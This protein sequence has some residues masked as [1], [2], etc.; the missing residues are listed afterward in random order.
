M[1]VNRWSS[2]L[3]FIITTS[4]F[5]VGLGNIWRFPYITGQNGGGAFLLIYLVLIVLIGLPLLT[6]EIALGRMSSTTTLVGFGQ[7]SKRESWNLLGWLSVI[8]NLLIMSYYVMIL[9][10]VLV[11]LWE[12]LTGNLVAI[13]TDLLTAHFTDVASS[14][15]L[16]IAIVMLIMLGVAWI[17]SQGF[18]KGLERYTKVMM[19]LL[20]LMMIALAVWGA[21]LPGAA[22]GYEW[23]LKPDFAK[24]NV[25]VILTALGQVFFSIGVGMAIAFSFGSYTPREEDLVSSTFWIVMADTFFAVL[26]GLMMFPVIF[27]FG[28]APDSGPNL[29]FVTMASAFAQLEMGAL[30]GGVFFLLL[31]FGGFTSLVASVQGLADSFSDRFKMPS[32]SA[33]ILV[34]V[35]ISAGSLPMIFSFAEDPWSVFNITIF[36]WADNAANLMLLP[37]AGLL[38]SLFAAY[39]IGYDRIS[40]HLKL[41]SGKLLWKVMINVIIPFTLLILLFNGLIF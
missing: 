22:K 10:W 2:R 16:I 18:N 36:S 28:L 25:Q 32:T 15:T 5:A 34:L 39:V 21:T 9:A 17:I 4:A 3:A 8:T 7:L 24:I 14:S 38:I 27:A 23:Y 1:S 41:R 13:D 33:L 31:F 19:T 40:E 29:I 37:V 30:L 20:I 6:T 26:A 12:S 35:I 11:Y